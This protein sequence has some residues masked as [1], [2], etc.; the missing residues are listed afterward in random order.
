MGLKQ[1]LRSGDAQETGRE[2]T[3]SPQET[4]ERNKFHLL[5]QPRSLP[6]APP[7][8]TVIRAS[9]GNEGM[10]FVEY[11]PQ[12]HRVKFRRLSLEMAEKNLT[13]T[14]I[15]LKFLLEKAT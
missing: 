9:A 11:Q 14:L 10:W 15:V 5:L 4:T 8:G 7:T 13:D 12:H 1:Q 2:D 3:G 6:L